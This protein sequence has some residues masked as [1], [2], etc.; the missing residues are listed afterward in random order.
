MGT[1]PMLLS[2]R[3]FPGGEVNPVLAGGVVVAKPVGQLAIG[4]IGT[5]R[6]KDTALG[7]VRAKTWQLDSGDIR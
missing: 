4:H 5:Q 3:T 1:V 7:H 2:V 6:G